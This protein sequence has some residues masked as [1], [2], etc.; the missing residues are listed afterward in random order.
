MSRAAEPSGGVHLRTE[1]ID[2]A[3]ELVLKLKEKFGSFS[4]LERASSAAGFRLKQQ[5]MSVLI[6]NRQCGYRIAEAIQNFAHTLPEFRNLPR[7]YIIEGADGH[8]GAEPARYAHLP[9][10]YRAKGEYLDTLIN[11]LPGEFLDFTAARDPEEPDAQSWSQL[12]WYQHVSNE[13][14]LWKYM[15]SQKK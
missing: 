4:A 10:K 8:V 12:D 3:Q 7:N 14:L 13:L 6:H 5:T 1:Q 11:S 2:R 9:M 15:K